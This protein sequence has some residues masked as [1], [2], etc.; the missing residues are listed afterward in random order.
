MTEVSPSPVVV[1]PADSTQ[2]VPVSGTVSVIPKKTELAVT[3]AS[4]PRSTV[5]GGAAIPDYI[6]EACPT[7]EGLDM[8][9]D[10]ITPPRLKVVQALSK[11][12]KAAGFAEGDMVITP[13]NVK[14]GDEAN[15]LDVIVLLSWAEYLCINPREATDLFWLRDRSID[16]KS[17]LAAKCRN[18]VKEPLP[19]GGVDKNKQ[20]LQMEYAK[21]SNFLVWLVDHNIA[22]VVTFLKGEGKYGDAF[23][24]LVTCRNLATYSGLYQLKCVTHKNQK[25]DEWKGINA[26]NSPRNQAFC[27]RELIQPM[28]ELH[29]QYREQWANQNIAVD[30]DDLQGEPGPAKSTV[31]TSEY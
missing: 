30:Y 16:N 24:S 20:P 26:G 11:D 8:M 21:A 29:Q 10:M 14:V 23:A 31:D 9:S 5:V 28:K 27:P 13:I 4:I 2:P 25:G 7:A 18:R 12:M 22:V 17:Q 19:E 3:M 6:K 1:V 15:P